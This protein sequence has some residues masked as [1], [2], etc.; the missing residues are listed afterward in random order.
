MI[1]PTFSAPG[2]QH[3]KLATSSDQAATGTVILACVLGVFPLIMRLGGSVR[4]VEY[5]LAYQGT[6]RPAVE[7]V[8]AKEWTTFPDRLNL[9][10]L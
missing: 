1:S 5:L 6:N 9:I 2:E 10:A 4:H 3:T 8:T 7:C